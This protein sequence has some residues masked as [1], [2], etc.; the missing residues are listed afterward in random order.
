MPQLMTDRMRHDLFQ[1]RVD[2]H[3]PR[4]FVCHSRAVAAGHRQSA[5][6]DD[7]KHRGRHVDD[8]APRGHLGL[9]QRQRAVATHALLRQRVI[10]RVGRIGNAFER[11]ALVTGLAAGRL[12]RWFAQRTRLLDQAIGRRRLSRILAGL[13]DLRLQRIEP[14]LQ[15]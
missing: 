3:W 11:R 2:P 4:R 5:V 1:C 6:L 13:V 9:L 7:A 15:R 12:A 10:D 14:F 8:L